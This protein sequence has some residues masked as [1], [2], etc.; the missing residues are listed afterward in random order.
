MMRQTSRNFGRTGGTLISPEIPENIPDARIYQW[1]QLWDYAP[2]LIRQGY[3]VDADRVLDLL[4]EWD[5][6]GEW[7]TAEALEFLHA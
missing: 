6:T 7:P 3:A 5:R 4:M 2:E 1:Q